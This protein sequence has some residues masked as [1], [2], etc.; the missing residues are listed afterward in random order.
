MCNVCESWQLSNTKFDSFLYIFIIYSKSDEVLTMFGS[1]TKVSS[2]L[3]DSVIEWK[4]VFRSHCK[5]S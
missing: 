5:M 3:M 2:E 1:V 4:K